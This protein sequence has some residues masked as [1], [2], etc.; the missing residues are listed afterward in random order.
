MVVNNGSYVAG[1]EATVSKDWVDLVDGKTHQS[2]QS[3]VLI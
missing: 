3:D 2:L 1:A